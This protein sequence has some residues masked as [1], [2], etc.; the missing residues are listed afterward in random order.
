MSSPG[1][2]ARALQLP[3]GARFYRC[4]LQVN[5]FA[6]L[7]RHSKAT[8]FSDESAYNAAIVQ[9]CKD[10]RTRLKHNSLARPPPARAQELLLYR[11]VVYL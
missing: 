2:I 3:S 7:Q 6:Y 8:A 11:F 10:N 9:A 1:P 4:A 5:P